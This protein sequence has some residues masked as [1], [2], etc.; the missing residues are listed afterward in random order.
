MKSFIK[1][2]VFLLATFAL[3]LSFYAT[4][5]AEGTATYEEGAKNLFLLPEA[6]IHQLISPT[7]LPIH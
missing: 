2:T 1:K 4:A 3:T 6:V 7:R 5:F